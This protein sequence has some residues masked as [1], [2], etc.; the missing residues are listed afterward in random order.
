MREKRNVR[1]VLV[2]KPEGKRQL[3]R[4]RFRDE[5]IKIYFTEVS[6]DFSNGFIWLRK[7]TVRDC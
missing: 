6:W 2:R 7:G 5:N 1:S 3:A 4:P